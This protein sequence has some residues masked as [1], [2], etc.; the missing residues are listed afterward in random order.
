MNSWISM[1]SYMHSWISMNSDIYCLSGLFLIHQNSW[2]HEFPWIH[3]WILIWIV[4]Q[5]ASWYTRTHSFSWNHARFHELWP[6][7][8]EEIILE[9]MLEEYYE[10]WWKILWFHGTFKKNT[11]LN[12]LK[13]WADAQCLPFNKMAENSLEYSWIPLRS[14]G[15]KDCLYWYFQHMKTEKDV[16]VFHLTIFPCFSCLKA[17]WRSNCSAPS[18]YCP[19][20]W[21]LW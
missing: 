8:I 5:D 2:I 14:V 6:F 17:F 3:I 11:S 19:F 13:L 4:C 21:S 20:C 7:F 16:L 1:K 10:I 15:F 18:G 12:S 9:T